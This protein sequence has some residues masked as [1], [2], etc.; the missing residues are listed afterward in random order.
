VTSIARTN[1]AKVHARR[2]YKCTACGKIVRGNGGRSSHRYSHQRRG[3]ACTV[4]PYA[5]QGAR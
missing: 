5:G 2:W 1:A 4:P 3:E